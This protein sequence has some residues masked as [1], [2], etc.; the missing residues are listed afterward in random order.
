MHSVNGAKF[1]Y[2]TFVLTLFGSGC[3][4]AVFGT[5]IIPLASIYASPLSHKL[6]ADFVVLNLLILRFI[7]IS[8]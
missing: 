8:Y 7:Y 3:V 1:S 5:D 4:A 2:I 6:D